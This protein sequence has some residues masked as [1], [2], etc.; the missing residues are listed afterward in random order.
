MS[1]QPLQG[2]LGHTAMDPKGGPDECIAM[3]VTLKD[4][5]GPGAE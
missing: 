5:E 4:G 3:E 1:A 2:A